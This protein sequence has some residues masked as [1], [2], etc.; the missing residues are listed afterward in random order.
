MYVW[1]TILHK[2]PALVPESH[3]AIHLG[4]ISQVKDQLDARDWGHCWAVA[5]NSI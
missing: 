4:L 2:P 1:G 3:P 5:W